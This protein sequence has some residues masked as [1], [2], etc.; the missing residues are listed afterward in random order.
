MSYMGSTFK[1]IFLKFTSQI[2]RYVTHFNRASRLHF[3][4]FLR[5]TPWTKGT[6]LKNSPKGS[7]VV[8]SQR[9]DGVSI[10]SSRSKGGGK[11]WKTHF[12]SKGKRISGWMNI[13]FSYMR[14]NGCVCRCPTGCDGVCFHLEVAFLC[15]VWVTDP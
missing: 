14:L 6:A 9:P 12:S 11:I 8:S 4:H 2:N 7:K 3:S 10:S 1:Q 15:N 13:C 5:T